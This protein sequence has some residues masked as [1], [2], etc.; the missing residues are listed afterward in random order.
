MLEAEKLPDKCVLHRHRKRQEAKGHKTVV[1]ER[2]H[3]GEAE[4]PLLVEP[5]VNVYNYR[6]QRQDKGEQRI[7]LELRSD[8]RANRIDNRERFAKVHAALTPGGRVLIRDVVMD[9]SRTS[10]RGG[11]LFAVNM[12][13]NTPGGGTFTFA[14]LGKE[15]TEAGF[16]DPVLLR[17]DE[18]M[19][20]VVQA[21]KA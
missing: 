21:V 9:E 11:A 1:D 3:G 13:V 18:F 6:N 15:L 17:Q 2:E 4:L 16:A 7:N 8:L 19:N 12:L 20:S 10:P 14:E 5:Y